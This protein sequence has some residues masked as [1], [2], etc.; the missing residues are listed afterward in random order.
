VNR[1]LPLFAAFVLC[2]SAAPLWT[3]TPEGPAPD[4]SAEQAAAPP[5]SASPEPPAEQPPAQPQPEPSAAQPQNASPEPQSAQS[6]AQPEPAQA[7]PQPEPAQAQQQPEPA[8][9]LPR[10][11]PAQAQPRAEA[12]KA[13]PQSSAPEPQAKPPAA[14]DE[15]KSGKITKNIKHQSC[16]DKIAADISA[17]YPASTGSPK[18]DALFKKIAEDYA[19]AAAAS[20]EGGVLKE[21]YACSFPAN[22]YSE[23]SFALFQPDPGTLGALFTAESFV[24]GAHADLSY[25]SA[26]VSLESGGEV[27][28]EELFPDTEKSLKALFALAHSKMCHPAPGRGAADLIFGIG[29][30]S[31]PEAPEKF[32][33]LRGPLDGIGHMVLTESGANLNFAA[34]EIWAVSKGHF[35]LPVLAEDLLAMGAKNFWAPKEKPAPAPD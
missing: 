28:I 17:S 34:W 13:Q 25:R 16:P 24:G 10:A 29:C 6:A 35:A 30:S 5:Q 14:Q 18:A 2:L 1:F 12:A 9:A 11:E 7:H 3:Q 19:A 8:Q 15:A 32:L 21:G 31:G 26:T 22:L 33:A 27:S 20:A 23:L 4:P